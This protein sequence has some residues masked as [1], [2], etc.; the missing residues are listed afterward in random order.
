MPYWLDHWLK[1]TGDEISAKAAYNGYM[2][3]Y[4]RLYREARRATR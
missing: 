3:R 4:M 1:R 2:R